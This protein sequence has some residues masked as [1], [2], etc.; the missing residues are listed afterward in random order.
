M[1]IGI[2]VEAVLKE[3]W[4]V[5]PDAHPLPEL[6]IPSLEPSQVAKII[7]HTLLAPAASNEQVIKVCEDAVRLGTATVC[8]NSCMLPV[9]AQTLTRLG[10]GVKPISVVAFPFGTSN[11]EGKVAETKRALADGAAEIDM[12]GI[13]GSCG[14]CH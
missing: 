2:Q 6:Q 12:V 11:T 1:S 7:D 10:G 4:V 14:E 5:D 8:V 9:T 13:A 3:P